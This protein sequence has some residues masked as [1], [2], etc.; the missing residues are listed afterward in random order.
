VLLQVA[1]GARDAGCVW[2]A[3]GM[4]DCQCTAVL[5]ELGNLKNEMQTNF[6]RYCVGVGRFA[7][8]GVSCVQLDVMYTDR[9]WAQC[10]CM[11]A[12]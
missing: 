7:C 5:D 2:S 10:R 12:C 4:P 6:K 11:R 9:D 3:E 1:R 8:K